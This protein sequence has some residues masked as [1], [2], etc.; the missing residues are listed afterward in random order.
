ML[1]R[2][3]GR[4]ILGW[5][6]IGFWLLMMGLL[7][8]REH[9]ASPEAADTALSTVPGPAPGKEIGAEEAWMGLYFQGGKVGWLHYTS[10]PSNGGYRIREESFTRLWMMGTPQNIRTDT[11][12]STNRAFAL[13]SF[14]FRLR[15][16]VATLEVHGAVKGKDVQLEIRSA[17]RTRK[18][19]LH[20]RGPPYLF[21]NLRAARVM[22][23]LEAGRSLR[24]P[25]ILPS[26]LSQADAV[27]TGEGEEKIRINGKPRR[28]CRIRVR[29]AGLEATAWSDREGRILKEIS[30]MGLSMIRETAGEAPRG[31][32]QDEEA[33]DITASTM[34]PVDRRLPDPA[35][36]KYLRILLKGIDP[37]DFDM[38]GGG[39]HLRGS[40]LEI[41]RMDT[42]SL[43]GARI[44]VRGAAFDDYLKATPFLQSDAE[45]I[46]RLARKIV[47]HEREAALAARRLMEW[48]YRNLEKRPTVSL[49][50]ALEVLDEGAGDCNEHA[51]LMAALARAVGL[52]ARVVV[53]VVYMDDGFYY[54]AWNEVWE[55][56]WVSLDPVMGQFPAD[57]THVKFINGGLEEQMRMARVIGRLS[58][59][60]LEAR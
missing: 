34:V 7:V 41:R 9:F 17:G 16:D 24:V 42:A 35:N 59:Q 51:A 21:L 56:A 20:L 26:T 49:P 53:G 2:G 4:R 23:G 33:V 8:H 18:K 38:Q 28:A 52:P 39:Q 13:T 14:T 40:I 22:A 36:L 6:S 44:P 57:V 27:L 45:R 43:P 37:A 25:V 3:L 48:V 46:Q 15:S 30:P 47:G 1:N 58:V 54:H 50:S 19:G 12:C 10:E 5:S 55:G 31:I 11:T 32:K 29:Y 60:I